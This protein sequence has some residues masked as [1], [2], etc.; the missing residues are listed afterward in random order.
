[1]SE[2]LSADEHQIGRVLAQYC[3]RCDDGAFDDLLDLFTDDATFGFGGDEVA[4]R[5]ALLAWFSEMQSPDKRGT[6]LTG[7]VVIEVDGD[8]A[9]A[10]SDYVFVARHERRLAPM[11]A[12]RYRDE[13][14]RVGGEWRIHRRDASLR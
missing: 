9:V 4:G 13:L 14:R 12:G 1:M 7:N 5:A 11:A 6:H 8:R 2:G 10:V 3:H